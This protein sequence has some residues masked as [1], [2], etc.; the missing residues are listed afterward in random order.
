M[1][2]PQALEL[3]QRTRDPAD[4]RALLAGDLFYL[5]T[6]GMGRADMNCDWLFAR[7]REV[8][9]ESDGR[10]D[11]WAREQYRSTIITVGLTIQTILNN[12]EVTVG[13][14]SHTRPIAKSFLKQIK[15]EFEGNALLQERCV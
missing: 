8:Q 13:I 7:C 14:F 1:N 6:V 9:A 12:P 3:Y 5:M 4:V 15:R 11:L 2:R 10:L